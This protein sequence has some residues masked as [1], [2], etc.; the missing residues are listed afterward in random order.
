MA[1]VNSYGVQPATAPQNPR[2][3]YQP[4]LFAR[5]LAI[6]GAL[7][8]LAFLVLPVYCQAFEDAIILFQYSANF[9]RHGV[10]SFI[11]NGP[12]AEGATD[13]LW[14]IY[15]AAGHK[16]GLPLYPLAIATSALCVVLFAIVLLRLAKQRLTFWN[17]GALVCL[18]LLA[19]QVFAAEAGFSV[20]AFGLLLG[21]MAALA[22]RDRYGWTCAAGL[23]LCLTRPDGVVFALPLLAIL[24]FRGDGPRKRIW[25]LAAFF[26]LPGLIYFLWRWTYFGHFLPLPFYVKSDTQRLWGV[27]VLKSVTSLAPPLLAAIAMLAI[28]L[29][30]RLL[31]QR[32]LLLLGALIVPSSLFY[33]AMRLDQNFANRFFLYPLVVAAVLLAGNYEHLRACSRP[34]LL[35]ALGIWVL[36]LS[37]FWINW[38]VIYSVEYPEPQVVA[39]SRE[40]GKL[41]QRGSMIVSESGAIPFYSQWTAYDPW[42]LN[43]PQFAKRLIQPADVVALHPDLII[44]HQESG[45]MPCAVASGI[46]IPQTERSWDNMAQNVIAGID[47]KQ[48]VQWLLPEYNSYYRSH[49]LRWNGQPRPGKFDYQCWFI[50]SDDSETTEIERLLEQFGGLS[51]KSFEAGRR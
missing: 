23:L 18:F 30:K 26:I 42:G 36:C 34:V 39:V 3:S 7:L 6:T 35:P 19:P 24:L 33:A 37:Y 10:I 45:P 47:Q 8:L 28:G 38:M 40:L 14:M 1:V 16:I 41:P 11:P 20:F 5:C 27:L 51:A 17:L 22:F 4:S 2:P 46:R 21:W 9:A 29:R 13:F 25:K 31:D 15:L 43:T 44:L 49:P 32:N 50:R 48:Y 12:R